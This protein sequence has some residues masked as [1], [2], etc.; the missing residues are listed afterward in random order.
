MTEDIY[1]SFYKFCLSPC[2][3]SV[4]AHNRFTPS[5]NHNRSHIH[6]NYLVLLY[7]QLPQGDIKIS[8]LKKK[9][10]SADN[11]MF[12]IFPCL[13]SNSSSGFLRAET[14]KLLGFL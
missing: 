8:A 6:N 7:S 4:C 1:K 14:Q 10:F 3:V 9:I 5:L 13:F 11:L 12:L 2:V